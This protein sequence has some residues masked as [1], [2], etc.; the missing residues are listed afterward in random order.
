MHEQDR[1]SLRGQLIFLVDPPHFKVGL[2]LSLKVEGL[3]G[4]TLLANE[5]V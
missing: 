1:V 2:I 3:E 4:K 5:L